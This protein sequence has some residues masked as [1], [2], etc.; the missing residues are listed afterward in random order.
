MAFSKF[1]KSGTIDLILFL[2]VAI[3]GIETRWSAKSAMSE[4]SP[5]EPNKQRP[6]SIKWGSNTAKV[7]LA[8]T[9]NTSESRESRDSAAL[10]LPNLPRSAF[11]TWQAHDWRLCNQMIEWQVQVSYKSGTNK[12]RS[13][14]RWVRW[15]PMFVL[16]GVCLFAKNMP[17]YQLNLN[18]FF[19]III[20]LGCC[21][22][23]IWRGGAEARYWIVTKS[24]RDTWYQPF[25]HSIDWLLQ[26]SL[27]LTMHSVQQ[28]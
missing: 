1:P 9:A 11:F 24:I 16:A 20:Q 6:I 22:F 21:K 2:Y 3:D 18:N 25:L 7:A 8:I 13:V 12:I 27:A 28:L 4:W 26:R 14:V 19:N 17:S 23:P 5:L 15:V 10:G